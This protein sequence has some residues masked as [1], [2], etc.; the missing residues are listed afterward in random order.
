MERCVRPASAFKTNRFSDKGKTYA[1][2]HEHDLH[3]TGLQGL[4]EQDLTFHHINKRSVLS[5]GG[6][7]DPYWQ[8]TRARVSGSDKRISE[9][10]PRT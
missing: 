9:H 10:V 1:R 2:V 4:T 5:N 7:A 3:G 8:A 6:H